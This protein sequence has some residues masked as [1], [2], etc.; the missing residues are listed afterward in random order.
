MKRALR[1]D[2]AHALKRALLDYIGER[3]DHKL[4]RR[5]VY[6]YRK[7]LAANQECWAMVG[8]AYLACDQYA[9]VINWMQDWRRRPDTP[10]WALDNLAVALRS[11][12]RHDDARVLSLRSLELAPGNL[13][14]KTWLAVDAARRDNL[15][16]LQHL[17]DSIPPQNVREFYQNLLAAMQAYL[18]AARTGDSRKALAGYARLAQ[19][20]RSSVTLRDLMR[21]LG[22]QL[23]T[24]YTPPL[25]RPWRW[26]QLVVG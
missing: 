17:L 19:K 21:T 20:R 15:T 5:F 3:R 2:P 12:R 11:L 16:D 7:A 23:V 22:R 13:D 9:D 10:S 4:L 8:Y 14:A 26:I 18:H 6:D 24:K 25:S 1:Q